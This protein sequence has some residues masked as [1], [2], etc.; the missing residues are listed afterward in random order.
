MSVGMSGTGSISGKVKRRPSLRMEN[1]G[2]STQ[3][4]PLYSLARD[5]SLTFVSK[6]V[7]LSSCLESRRKGPTGNR[8]HFFDEI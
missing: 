2:E 1:V 6:G 7:A 8:F 3:V 5:P 4:L